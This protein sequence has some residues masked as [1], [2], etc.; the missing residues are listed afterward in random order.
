MLGGVDVVKAWSVVLGL[1]EA[2]SG[3]LW[4]IV[5]LMV[6]RPLISACIDVVGVSE[7]RELEDVGEVKVTIGDE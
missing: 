2:R 7:N 1:E 6:E 4:N 5:E 3:E